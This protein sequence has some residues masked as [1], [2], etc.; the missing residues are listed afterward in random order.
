MDVRDPRADEYNATVD[1]LVRIVQ[2]KGFND[3]KQVA[4]LLLASVKVLVGVLA[5]KPGRRGRL[6]NVMGDEYRRLL[7]TYLP[8]NHEPKS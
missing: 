1:D 4:V 3:D 2:G 6:I 5:K 8:L 7:K